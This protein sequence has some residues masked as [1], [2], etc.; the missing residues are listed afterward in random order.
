MELNRLC[1]QYCKLVSKKRFPNDD[2]LEI[3]KHCAGEVVEAAVVSYDGAD[4]FIE[5]TI[6]ILLCCFAILGDIGGDF[7]IEKALA[8]GIYKNADRISRKDW[9][10]DLTAFIEDLFLRED[11]IEPITVFPNC[12]EEPIENLVAR[13]KQ[14]KINLAEMEFV[15]DLRF[16]EIEG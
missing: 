10:D 1:S 15:R 8:E 9:D 13:I 16:S 5:E 14:A 2:A 7:S 6:D 4:L 3:L 11:A 12:K